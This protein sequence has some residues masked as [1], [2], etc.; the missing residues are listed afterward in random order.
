M[1]LRGN[2]VTEAILKV[3]FVV[4]IALW[5]GFFARELFVKNNIRDY[6]ALLSRTLEGKHAYVTGDKLYGF[7]AYCKKNM[8]DNATYKLVGFDEGAL[9][10]R[11]AVYYLYP[12]IENRDP[13]FVI[14]M[15]QY[16]LKKVKPCTVPNPNEVSG[17]W[18][19]SW[20]KP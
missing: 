17:S 14:D 11:R 18:T 7:L 1:S 9:E 2:K 15:V 10:R 4:W 12:N 20:V 6:T 13:D 19:G 8:T 16:T 5:I 3:L